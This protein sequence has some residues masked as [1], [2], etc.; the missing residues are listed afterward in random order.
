MVVFDMLMVRGA[1]HSARNDGGDTPLHLAAA[2]GNKDIAVKVK[3][4][5]FY[6]LVLFTMLNNFCVFL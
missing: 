3:G 4:F 6:F 2:H 1:R 5:F